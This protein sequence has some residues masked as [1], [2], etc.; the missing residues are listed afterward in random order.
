MQVNRSILEWFRLFRGERTPDS[1]KKLFTAEAPSLLIQ[2]PSIAISDGTSTVTLSF[3]PEQGTETSPNFALS[4]ARLL[5]INRVKGVWVIEALPAKESIQAS[6]TVLSGGTMVEYPITV[7]PP[8]AG[9]TA[10]ETDF[11]LF[12]KES[13]FKPPKRD[14]NRDGRHDYRDDY[15]YTGHYLIQ[16]ARLKA[17]T[18]KQSP[19]GRQQTS[20]DG[21][22]AQAEQK[23]DSPGK[24]GK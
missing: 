2:K 17:Q 24:K 4:G 15:I 20:P 18:Q 6:L 10:S 9:I 19:P 8:A 11:A 21:K 1:L 16:A 3:T 14:L 7:I 23:S 22:Q 12:L 5:S 13:G